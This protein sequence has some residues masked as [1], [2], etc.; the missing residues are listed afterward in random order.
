MKYAFWGVVVGV[1]ALVLGMGVAWAAPPYSVNYV[2]TPVTSAVP[3]KPFT[4]KLAV[5]NTGTTVYSGVKVTVHIPEGLTHSM[6]APANASIHDDIIQW[7]DVPIEAGKSFYPTIALTMASGT[8][9]KTKLNIWVE[10]TGK[11][12]EAN[13]VN[14]GITAVKSAATSRL[15]ST[16]VK[17][18]FSSVYGRTPTS[19]ELTYWLGRRSDKPGR[20]ALLGAMGYH[21]ANKISH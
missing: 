14:F 13:S 16:D 3:G 7:S 17:S 1:L 8:P 4:L 15:T 12:M 2:G 6:V 20:A 18:M 9:V 11:D 19:S 5:K 10:V 21:Q